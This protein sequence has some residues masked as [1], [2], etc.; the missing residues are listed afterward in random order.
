MKNS[1]LLDYV[2]EYYGKTEFNEAVESFSWEHMLAAYKFALAAS[3]VCMEHLRLY[4]E[5]RYGRG[6]SQTDF[7]SRFW[8]GKN[9]LRDLEKEINM[10]HKG[11]TEQLL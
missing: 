6:T 8:L 7:I 4:G 11:L 3:V 10:I 5:E 9:R 2:V 1:D